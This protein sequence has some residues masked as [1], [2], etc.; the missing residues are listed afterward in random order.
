MSQQNPHASPRPTPRLLAPPPR[1]VP[2][3]VVLYLLLLASQPGWFFLN[4]GMLLFW[5]NCAFGADVK[6]LLFLAPQHA[7]GTVTSLKV[8]PI[9]ES[10]GSSSSAG[11]LH[12]DYG[13]RPIFAFQYTYALPGGQLRRGTSYVGHYNPSDAGEDLRDGLL[14][15]GA[16]ADTTGGYE[17]VKSGSKVW[18]EYVG[19][20]PAVSRIRGM[21]SNVYPLFTLGVLVFAV[22]GVVLLR[23]AAKNYRRIQFLLRS[24]VE[25]AAHANL[26]DP[27]GQLLS[28]PI[29]PPA[30]KWLGIREGQLHAPRLLRWLPVLLIPLGGLL[31]NGLYCWQHWAEISYTW[32]ALV[33]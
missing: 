12:R 2:A 9:L 17:L 8:T 10:T 32:H 21:H 28:L 11:G 6:S 19:F 18:V 22:I 24:G 13:I 25:D 3:G 33:G 31:V 5:F 20:L 4:F 29:S 16:S 30:D 15:E 1:P 23:P 7:L 14:I 27:A 26:D